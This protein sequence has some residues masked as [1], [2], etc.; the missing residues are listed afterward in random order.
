MK[1]RLYLMVSATIFTLVALAHAA[2]L[3]Q[4]LPVTI[5]TYSVPMVLSWGGVIGPGLLALWGF[6]AASGSM[7]SRG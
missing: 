4:G 2:R 1:T 7:R 3:I 5:G 6:M